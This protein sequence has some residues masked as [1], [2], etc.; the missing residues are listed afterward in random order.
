MTHIWVPKVKIIE[1]R[2]A[3][4]LPGV[5]IA[6]RIRAI[7]IGP[8]GKERWR[9]PWCKNLWTDAGLNA[10]FAITQGNYV[11]PYGQV[12][13]GN[14]APTTGDTA[15][16]AIVPG[17]NTSSLAFQSYV[18]VDPGGGAAFYG[19]QIRRATFTPLASSYN[20]SEFGVRLGS[21]TGTMSVRT[22]FTD[23]GGVPLTVTWLAGET[24]LVDHET[25][26]Y[27]V[28]TDITGQLTMGTTGTVH[29]LLMR[30]HSVSGLGAWS[31]ATLNG[32]ASPLVSACTAYGPVTNLNPYTTTISGTSLGNS[33]DTNSAYT[34]NSF[35]RQ[36]VSTFGLT[37]ANTAG[38]I[39]AFQLNA[40]P[41]NHKVQFTPSI[42]K[43]NLDVLS[44]TFSTPQWSRY[45]P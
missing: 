3:V 45:T 43:T 26:C 8:D 22:L 19:G 4:Q 13:T 18:F 10:L 32:Y 36:V 42:P 21:T 40:G 16:Q 9:G 2:D 15:L 7:R 31:G 35:V 12:G 33:T 29:A 1:P 17:S 6:G 39:V 30:P 37:S 34:A 44:I 14:A 20:V 11:L 23:A 5:G 38:G 28:P 41:G 25:R 27:G 24:L